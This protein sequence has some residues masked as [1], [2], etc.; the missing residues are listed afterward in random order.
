MTS[1]A[2][3]A[4]VLAL[5][6]SLLIAGVF[7]AFSN[8]IMGALGRLESANGMAAMQSINVVVLNPAFL[9]IFAGTAVVS[10][11][12]AGLA[13]AAWGVAPALWFIAGAV[14]YCLGTFFL[15]GVGNVPL[16]NR[17]AAAATTDPEAGGLWQHYLDRW[18]RLNTIRTLASTA[19]AVAFL[20]GLLTAAGG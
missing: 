10:L 20:T 14:S 16:N 13:V 18:T 19:A 2:T 17:L 6:G 5:L 9:G 4:G 3:M 15:T 12:A 7:F 11:F 8:F 1:L